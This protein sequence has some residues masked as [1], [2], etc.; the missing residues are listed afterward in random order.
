MYAIITSSDFFIGI[1]CCLHFCLLIHFFLFFV[2]IFHPETLPRVW[3]SAYKFLH[4]LIRTTTGRVVVCFGRYR[5]QINTSEQYD[6]SLC[7]VETTWLYSL[8]RECDH[9][10]LCVW[11]RT[12][13]NNRRR[14][15]C[16]GV[17]LALLFWWWSSW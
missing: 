14:R 5:K 13:Y 8:T 12:L 15:P 11:R 10:A 4:I 9:R 1:F 2:D 7:A 3:S 17:G 16:R 6:D